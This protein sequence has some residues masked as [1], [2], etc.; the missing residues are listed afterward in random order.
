MRNRRSRRKTQ[1]NMPI[2]SRHRFLQRC[3]VPAVK[4]WPITGESGHLSKRKRLSRCP[5]PPVLRS[6]RRPRHLF[7]R[8]GGWVALVSLWYVGRNSWRVT[9]HRLHF[10][11]ISRSPCFSGARGRTSPN[12]VGSD[13]RGRPRPQPPWRDRRSGCAQPVRNSGSQSS[14]RGCHPSESRSSR[15]R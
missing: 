15:G 8:V 9:P 10:T 14:R 7:V 11:G 5:D 12:A 3:E 6:E 13:A 2:G 4:R 1:I